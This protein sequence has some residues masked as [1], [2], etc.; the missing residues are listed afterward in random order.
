MPDAITTIELAY[1]RTVFLPTEKDAIRSF[2][3]VFPKS[4]SIFNLESD[5][6]ELS[7]ISKEKVAQEN[8]GKSKK[9]RKPDNGTEK[10]T[11]GQKLSKE[12]QKKLKI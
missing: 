9:L 11:N 10:S 5:I 3:H 4:P 7:L 12:E 6:I 2:M 1:Q 8:E